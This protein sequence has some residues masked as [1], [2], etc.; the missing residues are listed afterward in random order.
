MHY[1]QS[2][3]LCSRLFFQ[4]FVLLLCLAVIWRDNVLQISTCAGNSVLGEEEVDERSEH[5]LKVFGMDTG[6]DPLTEFCRSL[7]SMSKV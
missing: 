3:S 4:P 5:Y 2:T 1:D 7:L 6:K